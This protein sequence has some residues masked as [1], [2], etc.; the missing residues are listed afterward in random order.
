MANSL[1]TPTALTREALR[2]L[3]N[4][5]T[6]IGS[7]N[8]QYD[9]SFAKTGAK[10]GTDLRIRKPNKFT[11][12][13]GA[14]MAVQDVTEEYTT[15]SVTTQK[16][17]AMN[18]SS[19][20]LTLTLDDFSKRYIDPAMSVLAASMEAD[21]YS[22]YK[23]VWNV[24]DNDGA[25]MS[26]LNILQGRQFLND[27]LTP[28]DSDRYAMLSTAH[29][30]K[31]VDALKGLFHESTAIK[32]QYREGIMGRTGGFDFY[33]NPII[34]DF[35]TGTA[36]KTTG[37]TVNGAT[38]SGA[39]ITIQTGSTTFLIG[40]VVTFVGSFAVHPE[41]KAALNYLQ[42]FVVTA[43]SGA[44]ATSLAI[45]PSLTVTGAGQNVSAFPTNAGAV[46]KVAAGASETMNSSMVYHKDAFTIATADLISPAQFGAWG[47]RE[48]IDNISM[49][50]ARQYDIN[51]DKVPCRIDVLYG[52][53]ALRPEMACRIHADG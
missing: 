53:K 2:I 40:D 7:I 41:T 5:A 10:I 15:L 12:T 46:V 11:V 13:T 39:A 29:T 34:T 14:T 35:T 22:M 16:H 49:R 9:D 47:A 30:A 4:K 25:A 8:K 21:A 36:A 31:V 24:V 43:N 42:K 18:F 27:N 1:I 48:V 28:M 19:A 51:N 45:S 17:V 44:S 32:E 50:I 33:E 20:D 52:F 38:Q 37:Y 6:F 23:N 3:H 26:F